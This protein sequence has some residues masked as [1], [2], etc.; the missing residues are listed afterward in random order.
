MH[1]FGGGSVR[2]SKTARRSTDLRLNSATLPEQRG[3]AYPNC[4]K[5]LATAIVRVRPPP[6]H[7][8]GVVVSGG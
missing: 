5:R 7:G 4:V 2:A 8:H 1:S 3:L 6:W